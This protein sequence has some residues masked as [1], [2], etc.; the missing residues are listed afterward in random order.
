MCQFMFIHTLQCQGTLN[1]TM[2]S[3]HGLGQESSSRGR[4]SSAKILENCRRQ[5]EEGHRRQYEEGH[6]RQYE[7]NCRRQCEEGHRRQYEENCR[8]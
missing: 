6:R 4:I 8:R 1:D 5:C 7:E 3:L 2:A